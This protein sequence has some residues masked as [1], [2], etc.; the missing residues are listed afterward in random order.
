M[1]H[2]PPAAPLAHPDKGERATPSSSGTNLCP[3]AH[4]H[5]ASRATRDRLVSALHEPQVNGQR[6]DL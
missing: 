2:E 5:Q 6:T 1:P 3:G 4:S